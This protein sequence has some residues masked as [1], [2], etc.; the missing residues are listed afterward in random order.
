MEFLK[1]LYLSCVACRINGMACGF[2]KKY[3]RKFNLRLNGILQ[4]RFDAG[5]RIA[6]HAYVIIVPLTIL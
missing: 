5:F 4:G 3:K 6:V 2:I 1:V